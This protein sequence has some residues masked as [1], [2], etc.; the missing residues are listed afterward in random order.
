MADSLRRGKGPIFCVQKH[1]ARKLH[2]DFR[3][4]VGNVLKSWSVPKRPSYHPGDR[5]L[6]IPTEDH[7]MEYVDFEGVIEEGNYGAGTVMLWDIGYYSNLL[8]DPLEDG[9][10]GGHL[11]VFLHGK[12]M[13]GGWALVRFRK[14]EDLWLLIKERDEYAGSRQDLLEEL[15]NSVLTDRDLAGIRSSA[16]QGN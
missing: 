4:Q 1:E 8:G 14:S 2:Y 10:E 6:A 12:K 11:K 16:L 5:R 13:V 15:P 3:L 7:P 9:I